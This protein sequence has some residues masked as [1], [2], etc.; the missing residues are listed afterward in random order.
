MRALDRKLFRDLSTLQGAGDHD[1]AG[2]RVRDRRVRHDP[3]HVLDS[4]E[5]ARDAY[6]E[7]YR[8][9]DVF[10]PLKRAPLLRARIAR[11][12]CPAWRVA[13]ARV[14]KEV[15]LPT[16]DDARAGDRRRHR[17]AGRRGAARSTR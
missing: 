2:R 11:R 15:S 4:L 14:V 10:A 8:F 5:R 1:R 13:Y 17:P 9:A 12:R 7:R 16:A 3:G 6:Y